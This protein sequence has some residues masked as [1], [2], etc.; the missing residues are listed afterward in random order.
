MKKIF[1]FTIALMP[2]LWI[3]SNNLIGNRSLIDYDNSSVPKPSANQSATLYY[4]PDKVNVI[5][6]TIMPDPNNPLA[7]EI[8]D[9]TIEKFVKKGAETFIEN[10]NGSVEDKALELKETWQTFVGTLLNSENAIRFG[11]PIALFF[12]VGVSGFYGAR[13]A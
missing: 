2:P 5:N 7:I 13:V 4:Y 3:E 8:S 12:V 11:Y 10:L 1:F 9:A 6:Q